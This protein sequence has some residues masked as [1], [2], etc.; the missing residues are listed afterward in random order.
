MLPKIVALA[1]RRDYSSRFPAMK[2]LR[3]CQLYGILDLSYIDISDAPRVAQAMIDGD[4]DLLQ[5]RGKRQSVDQLAD[6][7]AGLHEITS[8]SGVPLIVNDYAEIAERVPVEGIHVGQDD[9]SVAVA[10]GKAGREL[11]VGRSTHSVEQ[12]IAAQGEGADYIGFGPIFAT[13][14]KPDYQAIGLTNIEQVHTD[15]DLPIF[16]IGGIKLDN[17]QQ[18]LAAGADRVAIVSGILKAPEISEYARACKKLLTSDVRHRTSV[19]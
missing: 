7:A 8:R 6:L 10:R 19:S 12:A 14:T 2:L 3:E 1:D 4:V 18:V 11:I 17:L 9:D 15:V 13:P 5:L 16:C